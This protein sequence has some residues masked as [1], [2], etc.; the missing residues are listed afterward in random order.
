MHILNLI[1]IKD[2]LKNIILI[3][4]LIFS[5]YLFEKSLYFN[6][7]FGFFTFSIASST[8]YILN[9]IMDL[10]KDK[11]HN[12]KK[13]TKPIA[14]NKISLKFAY[15]LLF[16]FF[17]FLFFLVYFHPPLIQ[18]SIVS[19]L[20]ISLIYN[21]GIKRIPYI[22][23]FLLSLGYV[24]RIDTGSSLINVD[25]S[26]LMLISIFCLATFFI[27]LKRIGELNQ[28]SIE[29]NLSSRIVLKYYNVKILK[30]ISFVAIFLLVTMLL[31]YILTIN[32]N[33]IISVI[34]II[35][36]LYKY[37]K[38]CINSSYGENPINLILKNKQLLFLSVII[39]L[40]SLIIYF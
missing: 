39:L 34:L 13:F 31:I 12:T 35:Y 25:T 17:L 8:I 3:L 19:Y 1:R 9:D 10:D 16:L 36:F 40:S 27:V 37:Y 18:F 11:I 5:G 14:S 33:L 23:I 32:I 20:I 28:K 30:P 29:T 38:T 7:L 15:C 22:E 6:L 21:F 24:I 26:I 2:W 4:P